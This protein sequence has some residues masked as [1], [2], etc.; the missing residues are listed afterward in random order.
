MASVFSQFFYFSAYFFPSPR[1]CFKSGQSIQAGLIIYC[2]L[3]KK[4]KPSTSQYS[5][6]FVFLPHKPKPNLCK[7][8]REFLEWKHFF[9]RRTCGVK[10]SRWHCHLVAFKTYICH[11]T[12]RSIAWKS[13]E[14]A[15]STISQQLAWKMQNWRFTYIQLEFSHATIFT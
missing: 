8:L 10:I 6:Y 3:N 1:V 9:I 2:E 14:T 12:Q 11:P 7:L 4:C 15:N 13:N 5:C